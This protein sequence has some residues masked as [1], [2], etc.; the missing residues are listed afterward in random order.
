VQTKF[1]QYRAYDDPNQ[2]VKIAREFIRGKFNK[3]ST[4][5]AYLKQRYPEIQTALPKEVAQLEKASSIREIMGI[6]GV[7]AAFY[8]QEIQRIIPENL[9]FDGRN[10]GRTN[11]PIGA[12]DGFNCMLKRIFAA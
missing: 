3:T 9:E 4:V 11:R 10:A 6:E 7:V 12:S 2:R 1:V 5:L 8:W